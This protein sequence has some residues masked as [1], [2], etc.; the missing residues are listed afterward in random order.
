MKKRPE[1]IDMSPEA[2]GT[3]LDDVRALYHL[4][5]SLGAARIVGPVVDTPK[6]QAKQR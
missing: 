6:A 4:C 2:V 3:R 1:P 5:I